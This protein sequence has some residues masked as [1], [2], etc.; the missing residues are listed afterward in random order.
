[1]TMS[2]GCRLQGMHGQAL[3]TSATDGATSYIEADVRDPDTILGEA[4]D[5]SMVGVGRKPAE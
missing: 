1:M 3:L 4:D 2:L 5:D